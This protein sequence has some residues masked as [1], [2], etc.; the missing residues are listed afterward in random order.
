MEPNALIM[1]L[2][3]PKR[4][5]RDEEIKKI[6]DHV[7]TA[8]FSSRPVSVDKSIRG[9]MFQGKLLGNSEPS[10][11][12]HLAKRIL[13]NK[14]WASDVHPVEYLAHLHAAVLDPRARKAIY[15]GNDKRTYLGVLAPNL[16]PASRLG[17]AAEPLI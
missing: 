2:V 15:V 11:I 6:L 7:A 3:N 8:P 17:S 14:Q 9:R 4:V 5:S 16:I 13:I 1:E 10:I 12:A